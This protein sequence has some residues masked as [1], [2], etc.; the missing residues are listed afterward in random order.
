MKVFGDKVLVELIESCDN[1]VNYYSLG[2][3]R[4]VG[5]DVKNF[6]KDDKVYFS[7]SVNTMIL[8]EGCEFHC[9]CENKILSKES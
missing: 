4:E 2:E 1:P 5:H 6:K 9:L 8:K 7:R 3:I